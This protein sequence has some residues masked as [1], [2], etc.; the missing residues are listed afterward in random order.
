MSSKI[1]VC[2]VSLYSYPL[3]NP[4]NE[5]LF[6]G[7][8]VR[9][10]RFAKALAE[11]DEFD[12]HLL[13]FD[14]GQA[15]LELYKNVKI[16]KWTGNISP[17]AE[18]PTHIEINP[19][20]VKKEKIVSKVTRFLD[21]M[22]DHKSV[23]VAWLFTQIYKGLK[24]SLLI[25]NSTMMF[26]KRFGWIGIHL[27]L[28]SDIEIFDRINADVYISPGV[29]TISAHLGTYCR[30]RN[31]KNII[32]GASDI[33][34]S[35]QHLLK[36]F[37][38]GP[39]G[40]HGFIMSHAIKS[41]SLHVVQTEWQKNQLKRVYFRDSI[42]IENPAKEAEAI[43]EPG[44]KAGILWVGKAHPNKQ[45]QIFVE[46]AQ[47][48]PDYEFT[49]IVNYTYSHIYTMCQ[50]QGRLLGNLNVV[51]YERYDRMAKYYDRAKILV[52]TSIQE[53]FPNTFLD[54]AISGTPVISL[55][56]DPQGMLETHGCGICCKGRITDL[57]KA[58]RDLYADKSALNRM[59]GNCI[60]YV[61]KYHHAGEKAE[62]L[63]ETIKI[64]L[65]GQDKSP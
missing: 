50:E 57:E 26:E 19:D 17:Y 51:G 25:A 48:L 41:A 13:V 40:S 43:R 42:L 4:T 58:V 36:P 39:Y 30:K 23:W 45:P 28:K 21:L 61:R 27:I 5:S 3:F 6:G 34:Y 64:L 65:R 59:R 52:N 14:H 37:S 49:M 15:D 7:S 12:V 38:P 47:A 63:G 11:K 54:A 44:S 55:H 8:E 33:D 1:K 46:L 62:Q 29:N 60:E 2:F 10:A 56:V 18:L 22:V 24:I 31:K 20:K 35:E 16:H 53:G 32:L 9:V